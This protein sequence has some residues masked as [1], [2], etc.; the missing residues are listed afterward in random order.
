MNSNLNK[1]A[2]VAVTLFF[3]AVGYAQKDFQG[4]AYYMSKTSLDMSRFGGG[5][6]SEQQ[7]ARMAERMKSMLEKTYILNFN[8]V[9]SMYK[10]EEKLEAP[11]QGG[12]SGW[13]RSISAASGPQYKNVK[14]NVYL[15]E[16]ELMG[17]AFLV[18]DTLQPIEWKME[19]ETKQIGKY[20]VYKATAE[21][22]APPAM[23]FGRRGGN[24][25]RAAAGEEQAPTPPE[26]VK[27]T[28]W[29]TMQVPVNQGPGKYWGLPGLILELHEG[30]TVLLCT[31]LV[32]NADKAEKIKRPT[33]G[34]KVT[35]AEYEKITKEKMEEM[36]EQFRG[37]G[38]GRGGN[39][40]G[41]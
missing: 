11:G 26:K 4:Q 40:G 18:E 37:R 19:G 24:R 32:M 10:E 12:G 36:A 20:T 33:K 3:T 21:I 13:M 15:Q 7:K 38:R 2:I 14:E 17:K 34:K 16:N 35:L 28:A 1:I 6:M 29:Y 25:D 31:K 30:N 27:V 5:Q 9:E 41:R 8:Q 23:Q 39:R 22:D